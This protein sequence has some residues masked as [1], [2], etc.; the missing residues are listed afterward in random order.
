[1]R[2]AAK[3]ALRALGVDVAPML[4]PVL[5]SVDR[6]AR[7]GAAEVLQDLGVVDHLLLTE[8]D[9]ALLARIFAAGEAG[10]LDA[11]RIRLDVGSNTEADPGTTS[12]VPTGGEAAAA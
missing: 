3:D 11:A 4:V 1:V 2:S 9:S 10:L 6:F 8:P 5:E 12:S 7:N